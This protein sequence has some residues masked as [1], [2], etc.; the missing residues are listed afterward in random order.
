[1]KPHALSVCGQGQ[2]RAEP[3]G[4]PGGGLMAI[5]EPSL[6]CGQVRA[7]VLCF[8]G[9]AWP[10]DVTL[11]VWGVAGVCMGTPEAVH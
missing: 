8:R 9:G 5:L 1:M 10:E 2:V 4:T 7:L 3:A 11:T 6:G